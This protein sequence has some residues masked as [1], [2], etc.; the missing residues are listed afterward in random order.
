M[1]GVRLWCALLCV[2]AAAHAASRDS[3]AHR[4][5]IAHDTVFTDDFVVDTGQRCTLEPG[6]TI[7]FNGYHQI[8]IRGM[9]FANG[10]A[11]NP[12]LITTV[13]RPRGSRAQPTWQGLIVTG[14][15]AHARLRHCRIEGAFANGFWRCPSRVDSC[16]FVGNHYAIYCGQDAA[17]SIRGCR[18][19]NNVNGVTINAST[20]MLLDNTITANM[21]GVH[22]ELAGQ[23]VLGRNDIRGN[24][25]DIL[26]DTLV[27]EEKGDISLQRFWDLMRQIY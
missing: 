13:D 3:E 1:I 11:A 24:E 2:A 7:R 10:T 21:I 14:V 5:S 26:R 9:L 15:G 19:Y 20:P 16:E 25:E 17:P 18:I 23:G 12:I 27:G 4:F 8:I 22:L 6:V